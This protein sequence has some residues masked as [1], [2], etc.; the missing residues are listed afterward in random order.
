VK[1]AILINTNVGG[2]WTVEPAR[3]MLESGHDVRVL[4]SHEPGDLTGRFEA[5]GVKVSKHAFD[6]EGLRGIPRSWLKMR[7]EL[8]EFQPDVMVYYLYKAAFFGRSLGWTLRIPRV[9]VIVGPIFLELKLTRFIERFLLRLDTQVIAGSVAIHHL[10]STL[11]KKNSVVVY[12]PCD[13]DYFTP[14]TPEQRTAAR[15]QLGIADDAFVAVLV[16]YWYAPKPQVKNVVHSKGHDVALLAW[17]QTNHRS[18]DRLMIVGGG[19]RQAGVEYRSAFIKDYKDRVDDTVQFVDSVPDSKLY[20]QA[21]DVSLAPSTTENLGSAAEAS[22]M[23]VPSIASRTGGFSEIVVPGYSG[24]LAPVGDVQGFAEAL[25]SA[26]AAK[27]DGRLSDY[28]QRARS[29]AEALFPVGLVAQQ[30]N[31]VVEDVARQST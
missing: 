3:K 26:I 22:A 18:Q 7:R 1:I 25:D 14:P 23:G 24:W 16:A 17:G 12:P 2:R 9:H 13:L 10:L 31:D 19:F 6:K 21:A 20:Y 27:D 15:K 5:A 8:K 28:G 11:G 29:M 30:I 4:L